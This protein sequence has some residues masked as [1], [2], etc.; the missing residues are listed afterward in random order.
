MSANQKDDSKTNIT[1][2]VNVDSGFLSG[3]IDQWP[4]EKE[5]YSKEC[6]DSGVIVDGA[7]SE[8]LANVQLEDSTPRSTQTGLFRCEVTGPEVTAVPTSHLVIFFQPDDDGD[9]QLHIAAI[10]GCV[11]SVA[12]LIKICPH[13][14]LLDLTNNQG[15]SPLHLAVMSGNAVVTRMLVQAGLSLGVRDRTG[16]TPLHKATAA[17][18]VECLQALLAPVTASTQRNS[19]INQRNYRGQA[20][21]H[22]AA[23]T[24]D[25]EALQMLVY[26]KADINLKEHLAGWTSLH[27]AS[28]R[29]DVRLVQYLRERCPGVAIRAEDFSGRTARRVAKH[30][31]AAEL[32]ANDGDSDQDVDSDDEAYD[33]DSEGETL[34]ARL[35][36]VLSPSSS[37][38][39][40]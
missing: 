39:V 17:G 24:G 26:Y 9:T 29:G 35:R 6:I 20:C 38:N 7:L 3:P 31:A 12:T 15:H 22:V 27:I 1:V 30:T 14:E 19:A 40:A 25:L 11:K 21:V 37:I 28:H 16:E 32:F 10:H 4:D 18:N 33:S 36:D 5:D 23:S 2:D 34:F 13:K 8:S